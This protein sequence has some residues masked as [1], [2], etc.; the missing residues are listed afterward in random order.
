MCCISGPPDA[1]F[2]QLP[3]T[4]SRRIA[5]VKTIADALNRHFESD[6]VKEYT[7]D[8]KIKKSGY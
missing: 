5:I 2:R 6:V 4:D 7:P 1:A 8:L 3:P